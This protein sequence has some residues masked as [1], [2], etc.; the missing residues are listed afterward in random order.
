EGYLRLSELSAKLFEGRRQYEWK[1]TLAFWALIVA[2]TKYLEGKTLPLFLY[3]LVPIAFG[4]VWLRGVYV[5]NE[6]DKRM[7]Y[8]YRDAVQLLLDPTYVVPVRQV[9]ITPLTCEWWLGFLLS[10]GT[11]FEFATSV[12]LVWIAHRFIR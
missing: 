4:F 7:M 6:N 1:V 10:W 3:F 2:A 9:K 8:S 5:A 11:F 12:L